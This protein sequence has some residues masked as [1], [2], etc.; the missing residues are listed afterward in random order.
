MQKTKTKV[1]DQIKRKTYFRK[2]VITLSDD[3]RSSEASN[4]KMLS[5]SFK[6]DL[7]ITEEYQIRH[8][9][10]LKDISFTLE[11]YVRGGSE[12]YE[13]ITKQIQEREQC[14]LNS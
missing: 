1:L 11:E 7:G 3:A 6:E 5:K 13:A 14:K 2:K 12:I 8:A 4:S 9:P 10:G